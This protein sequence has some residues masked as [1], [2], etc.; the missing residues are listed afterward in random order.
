M[1]KIIVSSV[2]LLA[3]VIAASA[4][5]LD[6]AAIKTLIAGKRVYLSTPYGL[7]FPLQYR[8]NGKVVG[9]ASGFSMAS[10][11]APK[12]TGTW[13]VKGSKLC[14]KWPSWYD[15]KTICFTIDKTGASTIKWLR[16]DGTAGTARIEG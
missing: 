5:A 13:W 4:D 16:D 14:Q 12:E 3:S 9:D 7:E 8:S 10:M 2:A 15:G 6:G 1:L 11:L